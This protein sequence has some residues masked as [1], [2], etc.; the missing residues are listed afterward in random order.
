MVFKK[1]ESVDSAT[2]PSTTEEVK[3]D[4]VEKKTAKKEYKLADVRMMT[5]EEIWKVQKEVDD[6]KAVVI[7]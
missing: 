6:W 3:I 2:T 7:S 5:L 4:V 1:K